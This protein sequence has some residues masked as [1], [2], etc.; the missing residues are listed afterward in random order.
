MDLIPW[1]NK[2]RLRN[3][4]AERPAADIRTELEH[5][6]GRFFGDPWGTSRASAF[7][8]S[9]GVFPQLDLAETDSDVTIRAEVPGL[10]PEDMRID[11]TGQT[12]TLAGEKSAEHEE[13]RGEYRYSER[14]F[15]SFSRTVTLPAGVDADQVEATHKD[16][17]LTIRLAK[18]AEARPK[19]IKVRNA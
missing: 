19:R 3:E 14:Q 10:R 15:G 5:L 1:R 17:I 12:L 7:S 8:R 6:F 13:R 4:L 2:Q 18:R 11:V 16:G 9:S